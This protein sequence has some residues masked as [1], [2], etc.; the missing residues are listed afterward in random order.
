MTATAYVGKQVHNLLWDKRIPQKSLAE[1]LG[2]SESTLSKKLRGDR[3]WTI[4]ELLT[5]AKFLDAPIGDLL[6]T[7]RGKF[8][9]MYDP[10]LLPMLA[11]A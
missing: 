5:A 4:E 3:P 10:T 7:T 8:V 2:I 9:D 6:P 11:A 1:H